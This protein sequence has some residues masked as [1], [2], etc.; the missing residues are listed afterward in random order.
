MRPIAPGGGGQRYTGISRIMSIQC[1]IVPVT[2]YQQNCSVIKCLD[3]LGD[4]EVATGALGEDSL[5]A[6]AHLPGGQG[7]AGVSYNFV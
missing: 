6:R 5:L 3:T 2:P 7:P 1:S 4:D